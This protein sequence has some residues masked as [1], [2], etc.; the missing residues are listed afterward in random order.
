M[1]APDRN[2]PSRPPRGAGRAA[3]LLGAC[4]LAVALTGCTDGATDRAT[5]AAGA[6]GS[7]QAAAGGG[8]TP[9]AA[10][11][12]LVPGLVRRVEPSVVSIQHPRGEGSG[13][14]WSADGVIVTNDHVVQGQREVDVVFADS[15]RARA[16]VEATSPQDDLAVL[17][18]KRTGLPPAVFA[19][20]QAVV[21]EL[22][23]AIG[24]PLGFENTVTAGIVSGLNR[25]I[26]GT[27][28]TGNTALVDLLQTDAPISPGNSGGALVGADG[29]LLGVNVA[30]IPPQAGSVSLGFAIPSQRARSVVEQLLEDGTVEHAWLGITYEVLTPDIAQRFGID[31]RAGV[32]VTGAQAGGPAA[33]AGLRQGD[34]V[35]GV[36][37]K[38]MEAPEDL[39]GAIRA[40]SPGDELRLTVLR[41]GD[42]SEVTVTLGRQPAA[43]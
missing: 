10:A 29:Q 32:I 6:T 37:G 3:A 38:A 17:R 15:K 39:L 26:P 22:A 43:R 21:G 24:N 31:A 33:E 20:R 7:T 30:Y 9:A 2:H 36:E 19:D 42:A 41:D 5:G 16:T 12:Q 34:V 27:A 13:V 14:V 4:L 35:T 11:T 28:E 1:R 25:S 40:R 18:T 8:L 23:I